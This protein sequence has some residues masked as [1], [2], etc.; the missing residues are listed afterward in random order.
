VIVLGNGVFDVFHVGH[1]WHLQQAAKWGLLYVSITDD[2]HVNKGPGR[3]VFTAEERAHVVRSLDC[4]HGVLIVSDVV[5]A[6][7][8]LKPDVFVKG[9]EYKGK[10]LSAHMALCHEL[11]CD[12]RFTETKK[13]SSTAILGHY[14]RLHQSS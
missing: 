12:I 4:V 1:V 7:M 8:A 13:Y 3:P 2:E 9:A 10:I 5:E 11:G 14:D 6:L